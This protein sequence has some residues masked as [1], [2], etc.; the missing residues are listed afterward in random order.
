MLSFIIVI[1]AINF[2]K[3][4]K[5]EKLKHENIFVGNDLYIRYNDGV[6]KQNKNLLS[7]KKINRTSLFLKTSNEIM[8]NKIN[9]QYKK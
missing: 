8:I 6:Y 4:F 1:L 5:L 2:I 9:Q 7:E 3:H